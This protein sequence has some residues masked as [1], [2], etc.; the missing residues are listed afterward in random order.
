M[1][2]HSEIIIPHEVNVNSKHYLALIIFK[3]PHFPQCLVAQ[4][5]L[6]LYN[7]IAHQAPLSME[8]SR[9]EYWRGL[10]FPPPREPIKCHALSCFLEGPVIPYLSVFSLGVI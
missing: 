3:F 9:Q 5:C 2:N 1:R 6:N 7:P 4:S 10:T 8:F